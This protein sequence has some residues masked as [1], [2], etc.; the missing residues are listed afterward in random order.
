[1]EEIVQQG[2]VDVEFGQD[3]VEMGSH[4]GKRQRGVRPRY[5]GDAA[6]A[7]EGERSAALGGGGS[8]IAQSREEGRGEHS[9]KLSIN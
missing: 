1:M 2:K 6:R 7:G 3:G 8:W 5:G 9:E 4:I